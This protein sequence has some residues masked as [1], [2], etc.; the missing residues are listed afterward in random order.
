MPIVCALGGL[1]GGILLGLMA[2]APGAG[3]R[4]SFVVAC[5]VA[6]LTGAVGCLL[7]GLVGLVV[8]VAGLAVGATPLVAARRA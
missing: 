6:A 8:M 3:R 7:Y 2:P 5:A 1:A 4:V